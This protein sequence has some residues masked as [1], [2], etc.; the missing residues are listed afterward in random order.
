M[1]PEL[2]SNPHAT[3]LVPV[4]FG[5]LPF[6]TYLAF[7]KSLPFLL[8][9]DK[10]KDHGM[11][12]FV[13]GECKET[14][15]VIV[16]EDVI[17]TGKSVS[18][19]LAN[20]KKHGAGVRVKAVLT[21]CNRGDVAEVDGVPVYSIFSLKEILAFVSQNPLELTYFSHASARANQFYGQALTLKSN[22]IL[23]C[24]FMSGEQILDSISKAASSIVGVKLHLDTIPPSSSLSPEAFRAALKDLC[25]LH[26]LLIIDDAKVADI[27]AIEIEKMRHASFCHA[28]T[29]HSVAGLSVLNSSCSD[30]PDSIVVAEMSSKG[31]LLSEAYT[32]ETVALVRAAQKH[33]FFGFVCQ[34]LTPGLLATF[35]CLTMSPGIH[36]GQRGDGAN[37][38]YTDP[39]HTRLGLFWIVGR[40]ITQS[41]DIAAAAAEYRSKGWPYFVNY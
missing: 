31:S 40:G 20:M 37:Q 16:I 36:L 21:I 2:W 14:D 10:P 5:G 12:N 33:K 23:S 19:M 15:D 27:E 11:G 34:S 13:E 3:R 6:G 9:R 7:S 18:E 1:F 39:T 25:A 38:Q 4:P 41:A 8:V 17:S 28:T 26:H 22:I 35:E 24:D 29:V 30:I 32:R